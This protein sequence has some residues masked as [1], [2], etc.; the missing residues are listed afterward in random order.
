MVS[1]VTYKMKLPLKD[2]PVDVRDTVKKEVGNYIVEAILS[3]VSKATS[4]VQGAGWQ[5]TLNK[6]YAK[7]KSKYSNKLIA[8]MELHGDMLDALEFKETAN[9][10]EV[11][12]WDKS[13]VP[14]ADGHNNF[15]GDSK[16]PERRFIPY[17]G[18]KFK[19]DILQ[20]VA[21]IITSYEES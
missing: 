18:Q 11:G 7:E 14:K 5:K 2:V 20:E 16:L 21:S 1:K 17:K 19:S 8:N 3:D 10:I 12:I 6:R 13:E 9:G 15:S 4:P